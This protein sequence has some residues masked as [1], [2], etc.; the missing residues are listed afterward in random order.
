MYG[1]MAQVGYQ[2]DP[3]RKRLSKKNFIELHHNQG[4][5]Q[6]EIARR[7]NVSVSSLIRLKKQYDVPTNKNIKKLQPIQQREKVS[8]ENQTLP[9]E[10]KRLY[11]EDKLSL[12]EIGKRFCVDRAVVFGYMKRHKIQIRN[13]SQARKLAADEGRLSM[14]LFEV[15]EKFFSK[16]SAEM[17]WVLGLIFT[18]GNVHPQAQGTYC[19]SISSKD[20]SLLQNIKNAMNSTHPIKKV[21]HKEWFI[22]RLF[23]TRPQINSDLS[24]LGI[25]PRKSL[26]ILFPKVPYSF[27]P[28]FIRGVFDGDGSVFFDP[29]S[30]K[31]PL[32]VSFTS[33]SK[34]F[35]TALETKLRMDA[36]LSKRTIHEAHRV[37][38]N[39][40]IKYSHQDSL[41]F[42]NYIYEG[43]DESIRLERKYQKF[44]EG[45]VLSNGI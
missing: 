30:K 3:L 25:T 38:T 11:W 37:N 39:Y 35:M 21:I 28:H 13:K 40:Y 9:K 36:G 22:Y 8:L 4:V 10:I 18:D 14:E 34:A 12:A 5:S 15:N 44:I 41:K 1:F 17:A 16:W 26:T 31:S 23:I 20:T 42:F 2:S 45:G 33:G 19:L 32:R 29:R 43:T 7:F 27:L 6:V 24:Q